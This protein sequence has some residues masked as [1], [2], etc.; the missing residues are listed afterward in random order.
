M[1]LP[2][3]IVN[4]RAAE[5]VLRMNI[6][7]RFEENVDRLGVPFARGVVEGSRLRVLVRDVNPREA[8][9]GFDEKF[10]HAGMTFSSS[11][12]LRPVPRRIWKDLGS[13]LKEKSSDV[14]VSGL[15]G[16]GEGVEVFVC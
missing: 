14:F 15:A 11:E 5:F 4:R 7:A 10:E 13:P 1:A 2:G 16:E 6:R 3:R 9:R 12:M 8:P